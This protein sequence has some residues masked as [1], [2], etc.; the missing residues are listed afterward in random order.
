[1]EAEAVP[2]AGA[3]HATTS[4]QQIPQQPNF[5]DFSQFQAFAASE[6][7]SSLPEVD[8][9]SEAAQ[10]GSGFTLNASPSEAG[11]PTG[12]LLKVSAGG[13]NKRK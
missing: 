4:P 11:F 3:V 13:S 10:V 9:H 2:G 7:P 12:L 5:A 8:K 6:Q 1:M